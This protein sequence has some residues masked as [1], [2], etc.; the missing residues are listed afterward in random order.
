MGW[1]EPQ[2]PA[3]GGTGTARQIEDALAALAA[4]GITAPT[5]ALAALAAAGAIERLREVEKAKM[6]ELKSE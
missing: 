5:L 6:L 3:N 4:V 1:G 2:R